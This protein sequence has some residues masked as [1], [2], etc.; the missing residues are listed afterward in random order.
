MIS[1]NN[2]GMNE[3]AIEKSIDQTVE[4][5]G[6]EN[7]VTDEYPLG[8]DELPDDDLSA[9]LEALADELQEHSS[10]SKE[11]AEEDQPED[12]VSYEEPT[13]E[14]FSEEEQVEDEVSDEEPTEDEVSGKEP[15]EDEAFDEEPTENE[16]S[17]EEPT[18]DEAFDEEPTEDEVS[19][20]EPT[21]DEVSDEEPTEDEV[22]VEEPTE[23]EVS[24]EEPTKEEEV[25]DKEPTED[26][27]SDEEPTKEEV[28]DE[29]PTED[30]VSDEEPT[31]EEVSDEEPTEEKLTD[32]I[33]DLVDELQEKIPEAGPDEADVVS[34]DDLL[35]IADELSDNETS[36]CDVSD[37]SESEAPDP[38]ASELNALA[39]VMNTENDEAD[40]FYDA[41][42]NG[43]NASESVIVEESI[44][45]VPSYAESVDL[46]QVMNTQNDEA[47]SFIADNMEDEDEDI[48]VFVKKAEK[49]KASESSSFNLPEE[50]VP[51]PEPFDK[52]IVN[53]PLSA[54]AAEELESVPEDIG[55]TSVFE[56][57]RPQPTY[58]EAG[59]KH[60]A[61]AENGSGRRSKKKYGFFRGF[62]LIA[63]LFAAVVCI[64][65]LLSVV[66][67]SA[68]GEGD[69]VSAEEYDYSTTSTIIKP[70]NDDQEPEPIVVPEF[71][72]EKLT[73]GDTGDMVDAVQKT[74][75]SLGYLAQ[76]KV[77]GTYDTATKKAV[78]QFQKANFLEATGEVDKETYALIF[79][80]N[81]TAPTT[82]TTDLP[83]TTEVSTTVTEA[84]TKSTAAQEQSTTASTSAESKQSTSSTTAESEKTSHTEQQSTSEET[85]STTVTEDPNTTEKPNQ[86]E[87]TK[88]TTA[89]DSDNPEPVG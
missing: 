15:M 76:N 64:A 8:F 65:W 49:P 38:I 61:Y 67:F 29:E 60:T 39:D 32:R 20:E 66:A 83:T 70:F 10:S 14:E 81:A 86:T 77:S 88:S 34:T 68:M 85:K 46:S 40:S 31:E 1:E 54:I 87:T 89:S 33:N 12:N 51:A 71:T 84:V 78:T 30:E 27:V 9:A 58:G 7:T 22:S 82:R 23:E 35:L 50:N 21:E 25:S 37:T 62:A 41:E 48:K 18:E 80:A 43:N 6:V 26:E 56:P 4:S 44:G 47:A 74:L 59:G 5:A 17:D 19:D 57:V 24:D 53:I 11:Q 72:A 55:Q 45:S 3:N 28:S 69:T 52:T 42:S 75:A 79:D 73:I 36:E 13:E 63:G 2:N 16:V